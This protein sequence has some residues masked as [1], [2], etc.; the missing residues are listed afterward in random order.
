MVFFYILIIL[1]IT[2]IFISY[3]LFLK[4]IEQIIKKS[5]ISEENEEKIML[6][7][8]ILDLEDEFLLGKLSEKDFKKQKLII[9]RKY[10][11]EI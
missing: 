5:F 9:Q 3:P 7:S 8:S 10:L 6:L 1:F 11:K 2:I 4:K